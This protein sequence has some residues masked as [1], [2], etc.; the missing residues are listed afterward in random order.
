MHARA[1]RLT[2]L[3]A[4]ALCALLS[5][6]LPS[7]AQGA[8]KPVDALIVNPPS[9]PVPVSVIAPPAAEL[10]PLVTCNLTVG[11]F[12]GGAPFAQGITSHRVFGDIACPVGVSRLDVQRVIYDPAPGSEN[13]AHYHVLVGTLM[14]TTPPSDVAGDFQPLAMLTEGAPEV[15]LHRPLRI[16]LTDTQRRVRLR[17]GCGSGVVGIAPACSGVVYLVGTAVR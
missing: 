3:A 2:T 7:R 8:L 5:A 4:L 11:R 12:T 6:S 15:T 9:R 10:A 17:Y 1:T 16:D 13:I 14:P